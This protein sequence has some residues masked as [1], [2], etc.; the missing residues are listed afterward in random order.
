VRFSYDAAALSPTMQ[1]PWRSLS[2]LNTSCIL[3]LSETEAVSLPAHVIIARHHMIVSI[4][5]A[6][7]SCIVF[8]HVS[9][10]VRLLTK[11]W[12]ND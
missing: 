6:F 3:C 4:Y 1:Q 9:L 12:E 10:F 11:L 5:T 8:G 7:L 2:S